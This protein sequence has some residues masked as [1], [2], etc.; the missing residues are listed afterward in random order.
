MK[1]RQ[2]GRIEVRPLA[3]VGEHVSELASSLDSLLVTVQ[4][5]FKRDSRSLAFFNLG[6][7]AYYEVQRVASRLEDSIEE[8]ASSVRNLHEIELTLRYLLQNEAHLN[9]WL[10]QMANDERE[11]VEGFLM[12][13]DKMTPED[14]AR[15]NARLKTLEDTCS[16]LGFE[17]RTPWTMRQLSR[18]SKRTREYDTFYKF[19]S[20]FVHPSSWL[21]NGQSVQVQSV[22]YKS[23]LVSL[24][25]VIARRVYGLLLVEFELSE[26]DLLANAK[27]AGRKTPS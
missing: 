25:Q 13:Q 7:R 23:L 18:S 2:R 5:R 4:Q 16:R 22:S 21:V 10:G 6:R 3:E 14:V 12:L 17:R 20:M 19:Y 26:S 24:A 8:L 15:S 27:S 11:I 1:I 9:Q